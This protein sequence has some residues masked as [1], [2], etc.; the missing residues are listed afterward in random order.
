MSSEHKAIINE[1]TRVRL[2]GPLAPY[3]EGFR[4]DLASKG[5]TSNSTGFQLHLMAHVSRWLAGHGLGIE[6]LTLS[7]VDEFLVARRDQGYRQWL[8]SRGLAP[9]LDYLRQLKALPL[10]ISGPPTALEGM[11]EE[12]RTYLVRERGLAASTVRGYTDVARLFLEPRQDRVPFG[13]AELTGCEV[14]DFVLEQSRHRSKGS[15]RYVVTGLRAL[16]R[17]LYLEDHVPQ[18]FAEA[19]PPT[20]NPRLTSLPQ[21]LDPGQVKLLLSSC[22]RRRA[23]GRRDFAILIMLVRLGLRAGE[24][25]ALA[26]SDVDW[27]S[28]E[29]TVHGKGAKEERLPLPA[30]VGEAMVGWLQRGRPLCSCPEVFTRIRAPHQKL[31]VSGVSSI[32]RAACRRTGIPAVNAHRLRH[33]AATDMLRAGAS[34]ADIC[35]VLRHRSQLTTSIYAKVDWSSLSILAQ[36]WPG[37]AS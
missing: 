20:A 1:S 21:G 30:D 18:D 37:G 32:V 25:V 24:V 28:G 35:Q 19:V 6:E 8:S 4:S 27:R 13:L 36:P 15:V 29:I 33:T 16:L 17:F 23:F 10:P 3:A 9:L 22:D 11:L 14:I 5:Y 34:L 2:T 7:R 12:F 31:S 26:L